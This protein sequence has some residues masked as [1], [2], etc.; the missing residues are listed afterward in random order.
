V[1]DGTAVLG[2][3]NL[4]ALASKPVMEGKALLFKRFADVDAIDIEVKCPPG[5]DLVDVVEA[6]SPTFGGINLEDIKAPEC[7]DVERMLKDSLNIPV[8]HD[9]QHGTAVVIAAGLM[10]A[11][12]IAGKSLFNVR[13][14]VNGAGAAAIATIRFLRH[15]G[16][17]PEQITVCDTKGVIHVGRE[18][19]EA[20]HKIEVA[21][22]TNARTLGEAIFG[23]DVFIG[24]SAA[25]AVSPRML[26][27]MAVHPIVFALANPKPEISYLLAR[28]TCPD[29]IVATGG[30]NTPNQVN[31]VLA[32]PY[33]FRAA[34]DVRAREINYDMMAAAAST[35][36]VL[37]R[38]GSTVQFGQES[39]IPSPFDDRLLCD[40]SSAVAEAAVQSGVARLPVPENY[41][42]QL[43]ARKQS[44][45]EALNAGT[46]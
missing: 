1:S 11:L 32:F 8:F 7:F 34:L 36:A 29:A 35:L 37:A 10:N 28:E 38:F 18:N 31:N 24:V 15:L 39:I 41:P 27:S 19:V 12:E 25:G 30:S 23:A 13:I 40:V 45:E 9:D 3:G 6:I 5:V 21:S 33:L 17:H 16:V 20:P 4:G 43:L 42:A 2:L 26:D 22:K 44:L 14:V 46:L